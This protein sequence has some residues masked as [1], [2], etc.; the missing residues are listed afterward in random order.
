MNIDNETLK[1]TAQLAKLGLTTAEETTFVS[2][3]NKIIAAVET[4]NSVPTD[5]T[6]P[7]H[8]V[9]DNTNVT[10]DDVPRPFQNKKDLLACSPLRTGSLILV[11]KVK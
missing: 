8:Q 7:T 11:P 5:M 4:L 9:T 10:R 1:H 6:E 2:E 3:L